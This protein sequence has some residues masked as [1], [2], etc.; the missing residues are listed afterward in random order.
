LRDTASITAQIML[1]IGASSLFSWILAREQVPLH[2]ANAL[3]GMTD[4]PLVFLL[5]INFALIG[6]GMILEPTSALLIIT[7]ILL[8]V[9]KQFGIDPLQFGSIVIF[10]LM[11]GL[12]TPPMGGVA[13]VLSSV[14]GIPVERVFR[15]ALIYMPALLVVLLMISYVPALTLWLPGVVGLR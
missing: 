3:T 6:L 4:N 13:F 12:I 11:I 1:I 15:G 14:T 9:A 10:N 8:P 2:V 7:P 5:V